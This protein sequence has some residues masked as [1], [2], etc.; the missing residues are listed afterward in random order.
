MLHV[1]PVEAKSNGKRIGIGK[2]K[3]LCQIDIVL[4]V[5]EHVTDLSA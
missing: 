1:I 2:S 5:S 4:Q 3:V